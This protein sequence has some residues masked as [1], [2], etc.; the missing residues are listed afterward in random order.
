MKSTGLY[1]SLIP[2]KKDLILKL[3]DFVLKFFFEIKELHYQMELL[4]N[5]FLLMVIYII[6]K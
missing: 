5:K 4:K 3:Q 6:I 2:E 1:L